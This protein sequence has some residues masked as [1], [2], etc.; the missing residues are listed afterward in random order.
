MPG[1]TN[2]LKEENGNHKLT[3]FVNKFW[4]FN[5]ITKHRESTFITTYQSWCKKMGYQFSTNKATTLYHLA[6]NGITTMP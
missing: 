5:N 6:K 4:H 3:D 2:H 1:I